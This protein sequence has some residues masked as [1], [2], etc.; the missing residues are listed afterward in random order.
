MDDEKKCKGVRCCYPQRT[1]K[2]S[3]VTVIVCGFQR[4]D[5]SKD[6][7]WFLLFSTSFMGLLIC[8]GSFG[9]SE[10][11]LNKNSRV[12]LWTSVQFWG[13]RKMNLLM[14]YDIQVLSATFA[15]SLKNHCRRYFHSHLYYIKMMDFW[16]EI[17]E[18]KISKGAAVSSLLWFQDLFWKNYVRHL[19]G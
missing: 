12:F 10:L 15:E 18:Q 1:D 4:K 6:C 19:L 2:E 9:P 8:R 13:S 16:L 11:E 7:L 3:I 5:Q 17:P 14:M